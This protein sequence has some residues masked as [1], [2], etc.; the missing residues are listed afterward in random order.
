MFVKEII[1]FLLS[2]PLFVDAIFGG[3][4]VT[5]PHEYAWMVEFQSYEVENNQPINIASCGGAIISENMILT[6]AH[7]VEHGWSEFSKGSN[8]SLKTGIIV[9]FGHSSLDQSISVNVK[10]KLIHPNYSYTIEDDQTYDIALLELSE[11]LKFSKEIQ[12]IALPEKDVDETNY[13]DKSRSKFLVAGWGMTFDIPK[14]FYPL[15]KSSKWTLQKSKIPKEKYLKYCETPEDIKFACED[16]QKALE[17]LKTVKTGL[18]QLAL[19]YLALCQNKESSKCDDNLK[20]IKPT[21][22]KV[23]E[24]DYIKL[25]NDSCND[26]KEKMP[27]LIHARSTKPNIPGTC[28]GDSG[29]PLIK[30]DKISGK[31]EVVGIVSGLKESSKLQGPKGCLGPMPILYTRVSAFVPWIKE[32]M[33]KASNPDLFMQ[34]YQHK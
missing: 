21:N 33:A 9:V 26:K 28:D 17:D 2:F 12:P 3:K 18:V 27:L 32:N 14:D 31:Y 16:Y 24:V 20:L 10:S 25:G 4:Y 11:D 19:Q 29:S 6:A 7:C 22:L 34:L 13:L 23:T 5:N 15:V 30:L 8:N 1:F